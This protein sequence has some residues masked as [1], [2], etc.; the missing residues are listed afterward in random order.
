MSEQ[1]KTTPSWAAAIAR[2]LDDRLAQVHVALPGRVESY[3]L[4]T[5]RAEI[6][7]MVQR[8]VE[9][10]DGDGAKQ[11]EELPVLPA[12]PCGFP[13]AG[14]MF[15]SFPIKTGDFGLLV[16]NERSIDQFRAGGVEGPPGDQRMHGLS[17]AVFLPGALVPAS[18]VLADAHADNLVLGRDGGSQIHVRPDGEVHVP[19]DGAVNFVALVSGLQDIVDAIKGGVPVAMDGGAALQASI[20]ALL[21]DPAVGSTVLKAD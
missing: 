4:S 9:V 13:R 10:E 8:T 21:T 19:A 1:S 12:V 17:G 18:G 14:G 20:V 3:D 2:A 15:I 5:Q 6:R 16:F 11:A 7:V